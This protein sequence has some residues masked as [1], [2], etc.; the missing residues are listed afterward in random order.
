[1]LPTRPRLAARS[2][3]SSWG[4][5]A[6]MTATR[7]SCGVQLIKIS[8]AMAGGGYPDLEFPEELCSLEERQ[9]HDAGIAAVKLGDERARA[10]LDPVAAGLVARFAA[11]DVGFDVRFRKLGEAHARFAHCQLDAVGQLQRN[12]GEHAVL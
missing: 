5:P 2:T 3:C 1:M 11:R 12:R 9:P 6:C 10:A 8:S 7:V 4:T